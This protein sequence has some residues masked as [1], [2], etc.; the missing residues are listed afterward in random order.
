MM[1]KDS[2]SNIFTAEIKLVS[3]NHE[4]LLHNTSEHTATIA[5]IDS[6][7]VTSLPGKPRIVFSGFPLELQQGEP[8]TIQHTT[9]FGDR[10]GDSV[11]LYLL[12]TKS[13]NESYKLRV[14]FQWK[15]LMRMQEIEGSQIRHDRAVPA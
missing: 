13:P 9:H 12:P 15:G 14:G 1:S 4:L 7:D 6:I 3:G 8:S 11:I 5:D 2:E 10:K